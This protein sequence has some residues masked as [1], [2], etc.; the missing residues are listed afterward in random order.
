MQKIKQTIE[1]LIEQVQV[2]VQQVQLLGIRV[3]PKKINERCFDL[4]LDVSALGGNT[5]AFRGGDTNVGHRK[6]GKI[7]GWPALFGRGK[8]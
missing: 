4:G 2:I 8:R 6:N 3:L 5:V 7:S 1:H